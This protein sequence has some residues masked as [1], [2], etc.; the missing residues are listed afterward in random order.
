MKKIIIANWKMNKTFDEAQR[1]IE[2]IN[3]KI[4]TELLNNTQII[5]CPPAIM[6][7]FIDGLLLDD[8]L[9]E[10]EKLKGDVEQIEQKELEK[11]IKNLR[12][13]NLG[14]QDCSSAEKGA[15]TGEISAGMIKDSGSEYVILGHSERR[16]LRN[17]TDEIVSQKI[18]LAVKAN[19]TPILCIG[20]SKA[21]RESGEF[22]NFLK[23]QLNK[24]IPEDLKVSKLILAYEPIWSIG[25]G[26][27]PTCAQII[28]TL[29]FI[30]TELSNN[31]N[32]AE[33]K[34]LYGGSVTAENSSEI[35][36][37][38]NVD[39]LLVGGASLESEGF[40]QIIKS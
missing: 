24:S 38:K 6:L 40:L 20:E 7:D 8:E 3:P 1:W 39:G 17:E 9:A 14:A 4:T 13:I 37:T 33:F 35:L 21:L 29:E 18:T 32:I 27:V 23:S 26:I 22:K 28:D 15:F 36:K 11:L 2:Y 25:T 34:I 5:L 19:L 16:Q 30:K 31:S 12:K 10:I